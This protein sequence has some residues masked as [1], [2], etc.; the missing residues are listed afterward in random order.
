MELT[1][2]LCWDTFPSR[3]AKYHHKMNLH[4]GG[5]ICGTCSKKFRRRDNL[6]DHH[7]AKHHSALDPT[8]DYCATPKAE[9]EQRIAQA[10]ARES[11]KLNCQIAKTAP[12]LSPANIPYIVDI[13]PVP[14]LHQNISTVPNMYNSAQNHWDDSHTEQLLSQLEC[15]Q[16]TGPQQSPPD[17]LLSM[18]IVD[19][20]PKNN[21]G[22]LSRLDQSIDPDIDP[23]II[24]VLGPNTPTTPV[25]N[26]EDMVSNMEW[27][28]SN[29]PVVGAK[30]IALLHSNIQNTKEAMMFGTKKQP[31]EWIKDLF[32]N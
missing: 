22:A 15:A 18:R 17:D 32:T 30:F 6:S 21:L 4:F 1:C 7:R 26:Y 19:R 29:N 2:E 12:K 31:K 23:N 24:H 11:A 28:K 9:R 8:I 3:P 13:T 5:F 25:F 20:Q 16:S 14:T 10:I 27:I